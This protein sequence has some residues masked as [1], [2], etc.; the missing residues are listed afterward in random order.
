M[1]NSSCVSILLPVGGPWEKM[2]DFNPKGDFTRSCQ[3]QVSLHR[4]SAHALN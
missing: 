4:A 3:K 2:Q 1:D